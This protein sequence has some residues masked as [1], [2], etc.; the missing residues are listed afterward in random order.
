MSDEPVTYSFGRRSSG[1]FLG[2]DTKGLA[3]AGGAL[4]LAV[5]VFAIAG[6]LPAL[7]TAA[8]LAALLLAPGPGN[9]PLRDTVTRLTSWAFRAVRGGATGVDPPET[10]GS[11]A[12]PV[13]SPAPSVTVGVGGDGRAVI[14]VGRGEYVGVWRVTPGSDFALLDAGEQEIALSRW[15]MLLDQLGGSS[16]VRGVQWLVSTSPDPASEPAAWLAAHASPGASQSALEDYAGLI[17]SLGQGSIRRDVLLAIRVAP[18]SSTTTAAMAELSGLDLRLSAADLITAPLSAVE[19]TDLLADAQEPTAGPLRQLVAL[20]GLPP[21]PAAP[22][23]WREDP[24]ALVSNGLFSTTLAITELPRTPALGDWCWPLL[25]C[26][27]ADALRTVVSCH[28]VP[29]SPWRAMRAAESA[30]TSA[31]SEM[32][33]RAKAGFRPRSRDFLALAGQA[34]RE[35]EVAAG[36]ATFRVTVTV[37]VTCRT[38]L[39]LTR[40]TDEL[41]AAIRR[42]RSE[43]H[44]PAGLQRQ[45]WVASLPLCSPAPV[46]QHVATTRSV[47]S[48]FPAQVAASGGG[49]SGVAL[50]RDALTGSPASFDPW[51]AYAAGIVTNPAVAVLGQVGRGKSTLVKALVGRS[52]SVFGR[53]TWVLDPK[54]EYRDLALQLGLPVISLRP[55]GAVRVNPLD[56][57]AGAPELEVARQRASLVEALAGAELGRELTVR[58]RSVVDEVVLGLGE[59]PTLADV[60][61]A[62]LS[63]TQEVADVLGADPAQIA[64]EARDVA[65]ALRRLVAGRLSGMFD[66]ATTVKLDPR[67][68]VIDLSASYQDQATLP[69][70]LAASLA[71]ISGAI[72]S[73]GGVPTYL[74]ADEAWRVLGA[75]SGVDFLRST[76]K[77]ARSLGVSLVLVLHR[78]SDLAAAG[79]QGS[80][81]AARAEGLWSD[82]ETR[83]VFG[84]DVAHAAGLSSSLGLSRREIELVGSLP[85]GRCLSVIGARHSLLDVVL[86]PTEASATDTDSVMRAAIEAPSQIDSKGGATAPPSI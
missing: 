44:R 20:R 6:L 47:R 63:P 31:E 30:R 38:R 61:T 15:G 54:G 65:L 85:R 75:G 49:A 39:A 40:A 53:R 24:D 10:F 66:G 60:V 56:A 34:A 83:F 23:W 25:S 59:C 57:P 41:H 27:P 76:V 11:E 77:L 19:V 3:L 51:A 29:L 4:L 68:G 55:G 21:A 7:V 70:V 43:A 33:R 17:S 86:T 82:V 73:G 22:S 32:A 72:A 9:V 18:R 52:V 16:T 74:V 46:E 81:V 12:E 1:I 42:A 62:M 69:P 45:G 5:L 78:L 36:A 58:E 28:L 2:L 37:T 14:G 80:A 8:L 50:G 67:G 79:D 64:G 84:Q 13:A 35:D 48:L 71:W 26:S